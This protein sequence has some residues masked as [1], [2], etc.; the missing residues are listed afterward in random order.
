MFILSAR[1]KKVWVI[2]KTGLGLVSCF[3]DKISMKYLIILFI[4]LV[5]SF[6]AC[7]Q[8]V[9]YPLADDHVE[10]EEDTDSGS[11]KSTKKKRR[12]RRRSSSGGSN[13]NTPTTPAPAPSG[14]GSQPV[15]T[16]TEAQ[17]LATLASDT[18]STLHA[19]ENDCP[20]N[21]WDDPN[22]ANKL[23]G[24]LARFHFASY[25]YDKTTNPVKGSDNKNQDIIHK[26]D[27]SSETEITVWIKASHMTFFAGS[28]YR[29]F[30]YTD[31]GEA[32]KVELNPSGTSP[33]GGFYRFTET[34]NGDR[35]AFFGSTTPSAN[36]LQT[37]GY[38]FVFAIG[39]TGQ[40][41]SVDK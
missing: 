30:L 18:S 39:R 21:N 37:A 19:Y 12:R 35:D 8:R 4:S 36:S 27:V 31:A 11:S 25:V 15:P 1:L 3:A 14:G 20:A 24:N 38:W 29:W 26:L 17:A 2:T 5:F 34:Y 10:G 41:W 9:L 23:T 32:P 33:D 40:C 16:Q 7:Q 13:S 6:S 22:T 28:N